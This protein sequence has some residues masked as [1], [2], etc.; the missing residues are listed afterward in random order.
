MGNAS[1]QVQAQAD[2]VT[3]TNH[4]EGFASAMER[5]ILDRDGAPQHE[6]SAS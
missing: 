1:A 4:D 6:K 2:L 5:F 3:A